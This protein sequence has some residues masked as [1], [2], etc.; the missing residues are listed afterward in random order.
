MSKDDILAFLDAKFS[1]LDK[2]ATPASSKTVKQ[3]GV[4]KKREVKAS[5]KPN[6][7]EEEEKRTKSQVRVSDPLPKLEAKSSS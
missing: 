6:V 3:S 4:E 2:K 1:K 5:A 7:I